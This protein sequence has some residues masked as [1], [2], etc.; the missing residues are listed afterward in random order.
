MICVYSRDFSS[1]NSSCM[2]YEGFEEELFSQFPDRSYETCPHAKA[3]KDILYLC[4]KYAVSSK[5]TFISFISFESARIFLNA[6][7]FL[8][9]GKD[10]LDIL[11]LAG[12]HGRRVRIEKDEN[13][14]FEKS[15][16]MTLM[17][18]IPLED[19]FIDHARKLNAALKEKE[20]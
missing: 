20:K 1:D 15:D 19:T 18:T 4:K 17:I 2:K 7:D 11:T 6:D 8:F 3:Y 10:F 12:E 14:I 9:E 13:D 5:C 16:K